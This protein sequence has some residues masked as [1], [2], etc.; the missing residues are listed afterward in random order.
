M[1]LKKV[2]A[3]SLAVIMGLGLVACGRKKDDD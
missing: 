3:L 1:R 2:L